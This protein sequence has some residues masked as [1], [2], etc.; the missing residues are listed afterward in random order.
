MPY[1]I[2]SP[3]VDFKITDYQF[4]TKLDKKLLEKPGKK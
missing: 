1:D 4:N 2:K 3:E